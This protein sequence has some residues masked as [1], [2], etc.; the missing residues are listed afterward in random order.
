MTRLTRRLIFYALLMVFVLAVPAT[1]LYSSGYFWDW[2]N[3]QLVTTG[4]FYIKSYPKGAAVLI[5]GELKNNTP[6]FITQLPPGSYQIQI[7]KDGFY[8]WGKKLDIQSQAVTEARNIFLV[9]QNPQITFVSANA[10]STH[11][12]FLTNEQKI[13][14]EQASTTAALILKDTASWTVFENN[15]YFLQKSNLILY[16]TDL[17][18]ASKEQISFQPLPGFNP[19]ASTTPQKIYRIKKSKEHTAILESDGRLYLLDQETKIFQLLAEE[20]SGADFSPDNKKLLYWTEH[21]IWVLWLKEILIQPIKKA[22]DKELINRYSDKIIQAIW[23]PENNEYIF[24][25]VR[26]N[27]NIDKIKITE[28]DGRDLRNTYD[29][30]SNKNLEIYYSGNEKLLYLNIGKK[31]YSLDLIEG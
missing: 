1:I 30:F 20:I 31:L 14:N 8:P 11:G 18:G 10:T 2:K 7:Q 13:A 23:F 21:E 12:Y 5:N 4:A 6:A 3:K 19:T 9:T 25:V 15:I 27:D 22:G 29:I 28:L 26:Q 16:K 17:A 24:F